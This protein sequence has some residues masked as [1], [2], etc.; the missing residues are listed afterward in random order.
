MARVLPGDKEIFHRRYA[1]KFNSWYGEGIDAKQIYIH[2]GNNF[3]KFHAV[4]P[5]QAWLVE[6]LCRIYKNIDVSLDTF[7]AKFNDKADEEWDNTDSVVLSTKYKDNDP[8][9]YF[10]DTE[11]DLLHRK[12]YVGLI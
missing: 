7:Q 5:N 2:C 4:F 10:Q 8:F 3:V 6:R 11:L 12:T 9:T 1:D